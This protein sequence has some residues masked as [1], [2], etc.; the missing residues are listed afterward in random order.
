[1]IKTYK[2]IIQT[3]LGREAINWESYKVQKVAKTEA[4]MWQHRKTPSR[5]MPLDFHSRSTGAYYSRH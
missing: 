2:K 1:M 4:F 3:L 5:N